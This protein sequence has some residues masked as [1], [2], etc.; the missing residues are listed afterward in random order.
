MLKKNNNL[1]WFNKK[2]ILNNNFTQAGGQN[3]LILAVELGNES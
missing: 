1:Y 2:I 3:K